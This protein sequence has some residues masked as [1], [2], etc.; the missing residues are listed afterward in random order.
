MAGSRRINA[1]SKGMD[2]L[3]TGDWKSSLLYK[4]LSTS[5][6]DIPGHTE[7]AS[8]GSIVFAGRPHAGSGPNAATTPTP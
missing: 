2:I 8:A 6:A 3:G 5:N 1:E 7:A 4:F